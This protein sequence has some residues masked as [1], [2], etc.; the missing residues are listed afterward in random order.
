LF[1]DSGREA[2][3]DRVALETELKRLEVEAKGLKNDLDRANG[4][5]D[6]QLKIEKIKDPEKRARI[7]QALE[8]QA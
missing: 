2:V 6:L 3:L 7:R 8:V 5:I 1:Y 4:L